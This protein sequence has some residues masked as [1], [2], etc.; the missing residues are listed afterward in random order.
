MIY[1]ACDADAAQLALLEFADSAMGRKYPAAAGVWER[2]SDRFIPFLEFPPALRKVLYTT[3]AIE[4]FDREMRKVLRRALRSR[5]MM[6]SPRRCGW[7]SW[8]P[9]TSAPPGAPGRPAARLTSGK[10]SRG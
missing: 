4:S 10:A 8:T 7:L 5:T 2:A 3:N 6:R 1:T 9:R